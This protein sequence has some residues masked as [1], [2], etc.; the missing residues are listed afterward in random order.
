MRDFLASL[1]QPPHFRMRKLNTRGVKVL[2]TH[3]MSVPLLYPT[4][5]IR[6]PCPAVQ[7]L[8]FSCFGKWSFIRTQPCL[9][10]YIFSMTVFMLQQQSQLVVTET[11]DRDLKYI[12]SVPLQKMFTDSCLKLAHSLSNTFLFLLW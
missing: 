3:H 4:L 10:V 2:P 12:L 1:V 9:L 5:G 11:R 7:I 6:K 8:L